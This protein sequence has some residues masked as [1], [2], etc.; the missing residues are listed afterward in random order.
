M[1]WFRSLPQVVSVCSIETA[2][3]NT[4]TYSQCF[5]S[6]ATATSQCTAWTTFVAQLTPRAYTLLTIRGTQDLVGVT[7]TD[8]TVISNIA[9]ALRTSTAYGPV[10]SN[11]RSWAVGSCGTAYEL[12][13]SG[14]TCQCASPG[15]IARPCL[16]NLNWGGI[17]NITCSAAS[18]T[19]TVIFQY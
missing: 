17:N 11:S 4:V 8:A 9:S 15:Y 10:T 5:T 13:A 1:T 12:S 14:T 6:G 2:A 18:Q 7:V 19:I 16:T 3:S